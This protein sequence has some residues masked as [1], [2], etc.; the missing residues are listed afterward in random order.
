MIEPGRAGWRIWLP[1]LL[2]ITI[3]MV[4]LTYQDGRFSQKPT[5]PQL[6]LVFINA[7]VLLFQFR[8]PVPVTVVTVLAGVA[9][10]F[11]AHHPVLVDVAAVVALYTLASL[12]ER[13][14]ARASGLSAAMALTTAVIPWQ[15]GG[16]LDLANLLPATYVAVAIAAGEATR[17]RRAL[18]AEI[19]QRVILAEGTREQEARR[20][21]REERIRIARDLHDI[22]AHHIALVNAQ[23]GVAHH[24]MAAHPDKA[25]EALAGIRDTSRTALDELRATVGLLREA[26][27]PPESRQPPPS[28][29]EIDA[30]VE[31]FRTAGFAVRLTRTGEPAPLLGTCGVAA[32]RIIQEALTNANK[33][34]T[35]RHGDVRLHYTTTDLHITVTNPAHP[36]YKGEGTGHGLIGMRERAGAVGGT[37]SAAMGTGGTYTVHAT[38]PLQPAQPAET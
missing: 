5:D 24:L 9:L 38:L 13:R 27:D 6:A 37:M 34:A 12:H 21:V 14:I 2:V 7:V 35:S 22:V 36:S 19:R 30:L 18:L 4:S 28:V 15:P 3:M 11:T 16:L 29:A 31:K 23:A 32:Y 8:H 1:P 25:R 10:P 20:Q 17:N 26:D 33:H